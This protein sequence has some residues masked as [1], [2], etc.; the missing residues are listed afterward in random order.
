MRLTSAEQ[1]FL[2]VNKAKIQEILKKRIDDFKQF[3]IDETDKDRREVLVGIT[4]E[5]EGFNMLL[6]KLSSE[7]KKGLTG[8]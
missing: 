8:I 5:L 3:V 2:K 6:E 4:K 1:T 7:K